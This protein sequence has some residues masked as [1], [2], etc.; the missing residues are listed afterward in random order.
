MSWFRKLK[1]E[2]G[3]VAIIFALSIIPIFAVAGFALDF[4]NTIKKKQKVQLVV[5]SAVLAAARLK[6]TGASDSDVKSSVQSFIDAQINSIGGGFRC[7]AAVTKVVHGVEEVNSEILCSQETTLSRVIGK[8]KLDFRVDSTAEYGIDK[9]DVAFMFDISGSM[10]SSSRLRNLKAAAKE[11]VDVLLPPDAPAELIED[12]R[13]AMISYNSMV[14][15]GQYFEQVTGVPATRTY[16]H[17]IAGS[18]SGVTTDRGRLSSDLTIELI[19][20]SRNRVI[21]EFGDNA[22]IG[23]EDWAGNNRTE[24]RLTVGITVPRSSYL[25]GRV[26]SMRLE[27][28]GPTRRNRTDS[29]EPYSLYGERRGN[30]SRR[31]GRNWREGDYSL[32]VR[33]YDQRRGRGSVLYDE[34][35]DFEIARDTSSEPETKTY[36]LTSTCVWERDGT[37]AFTDTTP[38]TGAYL[39]HRQAWF[40]EDSNHRDGGVWKV[41]HPNRPDHSWYRGT[42]CRNATPLGLTNNRTRLN[43][44]VDN[45]T[46]GGG[47]AGHL[48]VGWSWY[49]ISDSWGG[50]FT[51]ASTP[52]SF[53]EPDSEKVVIL[54]TDGEFNAEIFPEQGSSDDQARDLCDGMKRKSIKVYA[55]AL[56]APRAGR[57]VLAYCASGADYYF[58]PETA[59]ELTEAYRKIAT[60]ISDLRI[61]Q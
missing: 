4:Q 53:T 60:S 20:A 37:E 22:V 3:Q 58:E 31:N 41:G 25:R 51:G 61:S 21:T 42:E 36:T 30:Y 11:A 17:T 5:D 40:E 33:A 24:Q 38:G 13:L 29:G 50:I 14:N 35:F 54:M 47:T 52:L 43:T 55:V 10:N 45:L 27:L 16:T 23:I 56:N 9:L 18:D 19:D 28:R 2:S 7:N 49:L 57:E 32:R 12:T 34:T 15:A 26:G 39:A 59:A 48:G 44:Y 46:A 8:E 1:G 6:Q